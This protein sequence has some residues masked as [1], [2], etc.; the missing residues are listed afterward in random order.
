MIGYEEISNSVQQYMNMRYTGMNLAFIV[1]FICA[2]LFFLIVFIYTLRK[3]YISDKSKVD[4]FD[5][6]PSKTK[7]PGYTPG[8]FHDD[9]ETSFGH[10]ELPEKEY[11]DK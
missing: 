10:E 11:N 4:T 3:Q 1:F 9:S 6:R 8:V 5:Y 2:L 7:Y